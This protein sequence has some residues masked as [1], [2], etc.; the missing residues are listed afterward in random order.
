MSDQKSSVPL[1]FGAEDRVVADREGSTAQTST[2]REM[3]PQEAAGNQPRA[4]TETEATIYSGV[5]AGHYQSQRMRTPCKKA[6]RTA[7]MS[8]K[9]VSETSY[10]EEKDVSEALSR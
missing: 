1:D 9:D 8:P 7:G 5:V 3:V 6:L 10:D 4:R 2:D